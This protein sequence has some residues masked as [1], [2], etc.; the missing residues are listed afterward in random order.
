LSQFL[1]LRKRLYSNQ[2]REACG[3]LLLLYDIGQWKVS[4][5]N[6]K[7]FLEMMNRFVEWQKQN[8]KKFYYTQ[9]T[10]GIVKDDDP[11]ME[12]WMYVDEYKDQESYDKFEESFQWSNPEN[13]GF[14][15]LK[16]EFASLI[17]PDSYK[18]ARVIEK[19][20]LRIT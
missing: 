3:A 16:E 13:A 17:V 19:P 14:L 8:R 9:S 5:A 7:K 6:T 15:K 2:V 1:V 11:S 18:C 12:T 10:F 20:E 4:R